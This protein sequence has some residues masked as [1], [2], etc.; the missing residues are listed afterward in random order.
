MLLTVRRSSG[1][2][3]LCR[4]EKGGGGGEKG[5]RERERRGRKGEKE[6]REGKLK[7]LRNRGTQKRVAH[8]P[9]WEI[10]DHLLLWLGP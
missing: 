9:H 6:R 8:K 2:L 5:R 10:H 1:M 4:W 3:V 7:T